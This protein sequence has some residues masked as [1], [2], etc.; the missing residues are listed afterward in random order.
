MRINRIYRKQHAGGHIHIP[1]RHAFGDLSHC[2]LQRF[3][4]RTNQN[5][6]PP[7]DRGIG[8]ST[9]RKMSSVGPIDE[10]EVGSIEE[11][12]VGSLDEP[13]VELD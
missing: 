3:V 13:E 4:Q 11:P 1:R 6:V 2:C 7:T 9:K 8:A 12:E 10:P 5:N